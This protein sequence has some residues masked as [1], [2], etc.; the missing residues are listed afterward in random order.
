MADDDYPRMPDVPTWA[1]AFAALPMQA[2]PADAWSRI[3]ATLPAVPATRRA[4]AMRRLRWA[5]AAAR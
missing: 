5:T 3:R 2:P 4:A 1:Q